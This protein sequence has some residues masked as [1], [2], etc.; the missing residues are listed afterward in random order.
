MTV[1]SPSA[2][3]GKTRARIWIVVV[4]L[5]AAALALIYHSAKDIIGLYGRFSVDQSDPAFADA[6]SRFQRLH[7]SYLEA[8]RDDLV[9]DRRRDTV[10]HTAGH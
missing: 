5:A 10:S 7:S 2:A 1:G 8:A 6:K 4:L 9:V 3:N